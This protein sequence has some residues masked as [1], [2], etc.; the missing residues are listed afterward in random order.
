MEKDQIEECIR[1]AIRDNSL[2]PVP[3]YYNDFKRSYI[4]IMD[5]RNREKQHRI[6][7]EQ[8]SFRMKEILDMVTEP[9]SNGPFK[10]ETP[11]ERRMRLV[12]ENSLY[13][14]DGLT[15]A[16]LFYRQ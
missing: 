14:A 13:G 3:F 1:L 8:M 12:R 9:F 11:L 2:T 5:L 7:M 10:G 15:E 6:E 16:E 4:Q